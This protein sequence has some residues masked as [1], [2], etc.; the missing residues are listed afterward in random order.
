MGGMAVK[1]GDG[2]R[3]QVLFD[4]KGACATCHRVENGSGPRVAPDLSDV[5]AIRSPAQ[6]FQSITDPSSQMMPIN[7]PVQIVMRDGR[8][9]QGR[10]LNEDTYTVQIID[11]QSA[12]CRSTRATF[13]SSTSAP[14]RRCRRPQRRWPATRWRTSSPIFF[15]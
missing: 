10:R 15:R 9:F 6:L 3:G 4:A 12:C 1:V 8:T 13:V 7:R 5:G 11:D 2:R 14:P